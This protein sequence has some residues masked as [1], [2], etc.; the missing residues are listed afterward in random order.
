[1]L[2]HARLWRA[3]PCP[4]WGVAGLAGH[5]GPG[6][7]HRPQEPDDADVLMWNWRLG[8]CRGLAQAGLGADRVSRPGWST[9]KPWTLEMMR[10]WLGGS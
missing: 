8:W 4:G 3:W 1:M 9:D 2:V 5:A 6:L 10:G 7:L